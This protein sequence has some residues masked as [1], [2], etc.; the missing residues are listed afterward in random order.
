MVLPSRVTLYSSMPLLRARRC[1]VISNA[2]S[3]L[4]VPW[5][6]GRIHELGLSTAFRLRHIPP[7]TAASSSMPMAHSKRPEQRRAR[8]RDADRRRFLRWTPGPAQCRINRSL[9]D[10]IMPVAYDFHDRLRSYRRRRRN[11]PGDRRT[12]PRLGRPGVC[13]GPQVT[14]LWQRL[15]CESGC[16]GCSGSCSGCGR[17]ATRAAGESTFWS[18]MP[19]TSAQARPSWNSIRRMATQRGGEPSELF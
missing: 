18:T 14:S 3:P 8:P 10:V 12:A 11:W 6:S 15:F 5:I 7:P 1:P 19:D 9:K 17:I 2:A 16:F 13:L 4:E